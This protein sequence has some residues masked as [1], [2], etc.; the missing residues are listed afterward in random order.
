[1]MKKELILMTTC[2]VASLAQATPIQPEKLLLGVT[3]QPSADLGISGNSMFNPRFFDGKVYAN[4]I[5]V[6]CFGRYPSGSPIPEMLVDNSTNNSMEHRM[7]APFRG[8]FSSTYLLASSSA[9][10]ST[11][12]F[13][14]YDYDGSNPVTTD[15]P[16]WL[17]VSAF[18]WVDND[19]IIYAVYTSGYR[20]RLY[21]ADV[22]AEPF[23]VTK[24][25]LWNADGYA[26]TSVS[27]RIRNV[28]TGD[29]FSGFAYYGDAGQNTNPNFYALNLATGVETLL[30][31]A[32]TLTGSGSYGIWTV[33]ERDGHLYV[34]T[35]DNGVQIYNMTDATTLG[36]LH[37]TYT[38]QE[39]DALTG[40]SAQYF[41]LD[42]TPDGKTMLLGGLGG[43][44]FELLEK[45]DPSVIISMSGENV[46]LSWP[47]SLTNMII[48]STSDL[49]MGF[50]DLDPQPAV[51]IDGE[52]NTATIAVSAGV[53]RAFFRLRQ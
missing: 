1:M 5:N 6:A 9:A 28:R 2:L 26:A 7:V 40:G 14:R 37:A 53:D 15:A 33:L 31:N 32:G 42:V 21:L 8:S 13:T 18:D 41:G 45:S 16:D 36:S 47:A 10:A 46:V 23:T 30:G 39:L 4:Q 24:N 19:T 48:Q 52:M 17:T 50:A 49:S 3:V 34:Q 38:K 44:V 12:N 35:T 29:V 27:K 11:T 22:A 20:N 51:V 25:T 43:S